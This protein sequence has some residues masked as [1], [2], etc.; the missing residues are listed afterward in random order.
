M[1][2][3]HNKEQL[4]SSKAM[5]YYRLGFCYYRRRW[6]DR[7]LAVG[8]KLLKTSWLFNNTTYELK[9][10]WLLSKACFGLELLELSMILNNRYLDGYTQ[11]NDDVREL[12]INQ[13]NRK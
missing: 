1:L 12:G 3:K 2:E 6:Y 7:L 5:L 4:F 11:P 9:S 10:Y 8:K 13:L